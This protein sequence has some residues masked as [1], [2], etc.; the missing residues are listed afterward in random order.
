MPPANDIQ[1]GTARPIA[2]IYGTTFMQLRCSLGVHVVGIGN[3]L[4][5]RRR[6]L[7]SSRQ[8]LDHLDTLFPEYRIYVLHMSEAECRAEPLPLGLVL[9]AFCEENADSKNTSQAMSEVPR[10]DKVTSG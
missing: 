4:I 8:R 1:S 7:G 6:F 3:V 10:L 9:F 5:C 2:Y